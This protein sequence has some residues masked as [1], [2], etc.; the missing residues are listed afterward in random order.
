VET[1]SGAASVP[2]DGS[3]PAMRL[4]LVSGVSGSGK[5]IALNVLED[6]GYTCIDN[7]PVQLLPDTVQILRDGGGTHLALSIDSRSGPTLAPVPRYVETLRAQGLD[8]RVIFLD[9]RDEALLCRFSETRRRHPLTSEDRTLEESLR[10]E[11]ELLAPVAEIGHRIDTTGLSPNALRDRI[12]AL[13]ESESGSLTMLFESFGYK[14][15]I[16]L[17]ADLVFDVRCL[18][19]PHY[20]P[21]LRPLTG[22]DPAVVEFLQG[23]V[24]V[25]RMFG[26]IRA[27]I[28]AWLPA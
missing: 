2:G 9:A 6:T 1:R 24:Q 10:L 19:N 15:G 17:D 4:V 26:D 14:A 20:D 28:E 8:F 21:R 22:H 12:R 7:L 11:R 23:D 25:E 13:I 27:F 16:P 3:L 5:T 18:P